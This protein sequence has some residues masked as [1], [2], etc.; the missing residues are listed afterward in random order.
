VNLVRERDAQ[1]VG[2]GGVKMR[3]IGLLSLLPIHLSLAF[4]C[5][6]RYH[7]ARHTIAEPVSD[8]L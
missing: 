3:E 1:N 5:R 8:I 7:Y 2:I 4:G 6:A